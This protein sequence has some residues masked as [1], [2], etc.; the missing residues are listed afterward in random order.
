[1]KGDSRRAAA[2][3]KVLV[4]DEAASS[5]DTRTESQIKAGLDELMK[6]RTVL[7]IAHRLSTVRNSDI[8]MLIE[9]R[10]YY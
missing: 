6:N 7:V 4:L 5:I 2:R 8:I 3:S 10:T 1:M 9:S